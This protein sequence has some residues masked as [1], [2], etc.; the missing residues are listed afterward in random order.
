MW[1]VDCRCI[2]IGVLTFYWS[3]NQLIFCHGHVS[4]RLL[5]MASQLPGPA[6]CC[7]R[8]PSRNGRPN[9]WSSIPPPGPE[10]RAENLHWF[11]VPKTPGNSTKQLIYVRKKDTNGKRC[12]S[13]FSYGSFPFS[14]RWWC[15]PYSRRD[16]LQ[17]TNIS[18]KN[19]ILKMIFLFPRWDMLIPW[20]VMNHELTTSYGQPDFLTVLFHCGPGLSPQKTTPTRRNEDTMLYVNITTTW[21]RWT[22]IGHQG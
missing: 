21:Y 5:K 22:W 20:R 16:T 19:G 15:N 7:W 8:P 14:P 3:L 9:Q 10:M 12:G 11:G 17:G 18:P 2:F 4:H 1:N 6:A 13:F